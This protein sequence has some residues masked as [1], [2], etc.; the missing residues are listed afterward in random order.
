MAEDLQGL[1]NRIQ[2]DGIRKAEAEREKML[3]DAR[4]QAEKIIADA[5]TEAD[6]LLKKAQTDAAAERERAE[7][8]I[9]QAARDVL[10]GL[11]E[12][13]KAR[14]RRI[15]KEAAGEA[16][17]PDLI[18]DVILKMAAAYAGGGVSDLELILPAKEAESLKNALMLALVADFKSTPDVSF[19]AGLKIG[20]AGQDD[21]QDFSD[22][23]L[24]DV[25]CEFVGP[26]LA[27]VLKG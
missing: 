16:M 9:R 20:F 19:A 21:F 8:T 15:A 24:A 4:N 3:T 25:I 12:D 22:E 10:I 11:N 23:A 2:N 1:L 5:K 27:A 26:K 18:K 14:L 7:K 13:L 6:S 17:T